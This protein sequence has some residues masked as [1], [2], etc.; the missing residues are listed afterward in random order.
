MAED[1]LKMESP[2]QSSTVQGLSLEGLEKGETSTAAAAPQRVEREFQVSVSEKTEIVTLS[3]GTQT[4]KNTAS[5]RAH[6]LEGS[7]RS[8]SVE[9][10][11]KGSP[12][13]LGRKSDGVG[14]VTKKDSEQERPTAIVGVP[15]SSGSSLFSKMKS[16]AKQGGQNIG[17]ESEKIQRPMRMVKGLFSSLTNP[18]PHSS[19]TSTTP[20]Q[21][22]SLTPSALPQRSLSGGYYDSQVVFR[23]EDYLHQTSQ[24]SLTSS[25]G[26]SPSEQLITPPMSEATLALPQDPETKAFSTATMDTM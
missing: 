11:E 22:S 25:T 1:V 2:S 12:G 21:R 15:K 9:R 20:P 17:L 4:D 24:T 5:S 26:T 10:K 13:P 6:E 7:D 19:L 8:D 16:I 14:R 3:L 18:N 23:N